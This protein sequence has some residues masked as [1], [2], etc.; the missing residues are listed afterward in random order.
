MKPVKFYYR[1]PRETF[2]EAM[3][4]KKSFASLDLLLMDVRQ[5][6]LDCNLPLPVPYDLTDLSLK[7]GGYD[8]R[9]HAFY[10]LL[11]TRRWGDEDYIAKYNTP[12]CIGYVWIK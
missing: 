4:C 2:S 1:P 12:Q 7:F 11:C 3:A 9:L 6:S 8:S 5:H 10:Y